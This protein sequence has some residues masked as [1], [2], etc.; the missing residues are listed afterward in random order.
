MTLP[1]LLDMS[2]LSDATVT[3]AAVA[4]HAV[5]LQAAAAAAAIVEEAARA[6]TAESV[7]AAQT[8]GRVVSLDTFL[9]EYCSTTAADDG[10]PG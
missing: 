8:V 4:E 3:A 7:T 2:S 5:T 9:S 10:K 6:E 1:Q